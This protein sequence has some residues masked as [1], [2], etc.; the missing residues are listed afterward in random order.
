MKQSMQSILDATLPLIKE[1]T[2]RTTQL[3]PEQM[4]AIDFATKK[5]FEERQGKAN[6]QISFAIAGRPEPIILRN[7]ASITFGRADRQRNAIPTV[8]LSD[9]DALEL[10]VSR[11]HAKVLYLDGCFY[12]KDMGSINGTWLNGLRLESYQVVP[13]DRGDKIQLGKLVM[14]VV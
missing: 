1:D 12:I 4:T 7:T 11:L 8:D 9:H 3:N 14:I 10:G 6:F 2:C 5:L 13:I